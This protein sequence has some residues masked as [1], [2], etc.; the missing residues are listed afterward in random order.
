MHSVSER[1]N[2]AA[3]WWE[4]FLFSRQAP[5]VNGSA[6]SKARPGTKKGG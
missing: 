4:S 1:G 2:A 3:I 6:T 5:G